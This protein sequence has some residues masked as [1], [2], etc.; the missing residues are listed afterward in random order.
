MGRGAALKK[1][2]VSQR[3]EP[4]I[5]A[6]CRGGRQGGE[7]AGGPLCSSWGRGA[8]TPGNSLQCKQDIGREGVGVEP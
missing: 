4:A 8:L 2:F 3:M 5:P 1:I 6:L 7:V